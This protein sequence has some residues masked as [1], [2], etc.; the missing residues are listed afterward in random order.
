MHGRIDQSLRNLPVF[1]TFLGLPT[2][3]QFD[4]T[5]LHPDRDQSR[6]ICIAPDPTSRAIESEC[7]DVALLERLRRVQA[8][9]PSFGRYPRIIGDAC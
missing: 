2:A 9:G 5:V 7:D 4:V 3:E 8:S 6:G 1:V